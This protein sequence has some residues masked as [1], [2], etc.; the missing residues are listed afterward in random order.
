[1]ASVNIRRRQTK[2]GSRFQVRYRLGGR[3]YPLVHGGSFATM[4][5]ARLRRD[6]IG[7]ELAAGR[8]PA[9][10]LEASRQPLEPIKRET[11]REVAKRYEASRVHL[12][13]SARKNDS[14]HLVRIV[15]TLGDRDPRALGFGEIQ[16][17]IAQNTKTAEN[18][19]GLMPSSLSRYVNTLRQ[20]LDFAG[21]E[22]N[23]ARSKHVKLPRIVQEEVDPPTAKQTHAILERLG[24]RWLLP[25]IVLEQTAMRSGEIAKL[26]WGDVDVVESRFRL[27]RRST[28]SGRPRWV[29]VPTWLMEHVAATCPLE[30]RSA[31][32]RVFPRYSV[33]G[34]EK[35]MISACKAA[36][37]PR[38]TPHQLRHRRATRWHHENVP[39]KALAERVGHADATLTLNLYSHVLDPGELSRA[40]L[41]ALLN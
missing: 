26:V 36:E 2:S 8:N 28:K 4:K 18:E 41:E 29:Q 6:L 25:L 39:A 38:F 7:G 27:P 13:D 16:E 35:T 9:E 1:M 21:V 17:W 14:S 3:T 5:E 31:E 22:P 33:D 23:P 34:A 12:S 10:A 20:L 15:A 40:S 37:I 24:P 32:R 30:D 11:L 19:G